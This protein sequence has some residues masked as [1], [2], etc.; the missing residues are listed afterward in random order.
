MIIWV[1]VRVRVRDRLIG[2]DHQQ[3]QR[4]F[5]SLAALTYRQPLTQSA[6]RRLLTSSHLPTDSY[7]DL[8][9]EDDVRLLSLAALVMPLD[10]PAVWRAA[11]TLACVGL[12]T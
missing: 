5:I 3:I 7:S 10:V 9:T 12:G 8:R 2:H 1:R 4:R 6:S 11:V